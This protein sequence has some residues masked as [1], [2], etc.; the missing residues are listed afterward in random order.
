M[1]NIEP[2]HWAITRGRSLLG[3]GPLCSPTVTRKDS[4]QLVPIAATPKRELV[5]LV[6]SKMIVK[7][8]T[9]GSVLALEGNLM[10]SAT[11]V[12]TKPCPGEIMATSTSKRWDISWSNKFGSTQKEPSNG[13]K[14]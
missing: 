13:L 5:S 2:L 10:T 8:A 14:K 7:A 6:T 4:T 11:R 9:P 1:A 3:L 12:V